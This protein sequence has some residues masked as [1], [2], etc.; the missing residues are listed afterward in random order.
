MIGNIYIYTVYINI[1]INININTNINIDIDINI[2]IYN[3]N[4][5]WT[6]THCIS[7]DNADFLQGLV[8]PRMDY[9]ERMDLPE[10]LPLP[11]PPGRYYLGRSREPGEM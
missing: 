9:L 10:L 7:S 5:I 4:I 3:R 1:N 2:N 11:P 8:S 6:A